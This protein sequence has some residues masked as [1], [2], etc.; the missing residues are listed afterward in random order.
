MPAKGTIND[1]C[2]NDGN[3]VLIPRGCRRGGLGKGERVWEGETCAAAVSMGGAAPC[4][5]WTCSRSRAMEAF[6]TAHPLGSRMIT[7]RS[8]FLPDPSPR[9]GTA[10]RWK[11]GGCAWAKNT[12]GRRSGGQQWGR[13][14][15]QGWH[16]S[17]SAARA[18]EDIWGRLGAELVLQSIFWGGDSS[19]A[20]AAPHCPPLRAP[21]YA[22]HPNVTTQCPAQALGPS[23]RS[24]CPSR[25]GFS[26]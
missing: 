5:A 1:A 23:H 17:P 21:R 16:T 26:C 4:G 9:L 11:A 6:S 7:Y 2:V 13:L 12:S 14:Q 24:Q 10:R 20:Q 8:P 19:R 15:L 22:P 18:S 3:R 25:E